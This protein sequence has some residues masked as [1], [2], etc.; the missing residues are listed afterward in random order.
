MRV[1]G[2]DPQAG[3]KWEKERYVVMD[4]SDPVRASSV[5]THVSLLADQLLTAQVFP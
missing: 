5:C 4:S 2:S 1:L 3:D